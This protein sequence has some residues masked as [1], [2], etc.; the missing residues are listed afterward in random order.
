MALYLAGAMLL[1]SAYQ[2]KTAR[3]MAKD[4]RR[5]A[6]RES[7]IL[8][9]QT[10]Q[11]IEI[12]QEQSKIAKDRLATETARYAEQKST[13]EKESQRIA[14]E[15]DAERRR[16]GQEES[17]KMKARIRGGK[18]ALLSDERLTPELGMLGAGTG[19]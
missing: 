7:A 8:E 11:Q 6:E 13:M 18:R 12:Q 9:R 1:G 2:A 17:S 14:S 5:A 19:Y 10:Q 4:A 3:D 15:L 16:L